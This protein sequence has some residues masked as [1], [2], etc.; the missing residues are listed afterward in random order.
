MGLAAR[1]F[2]AFP[3]AALDKPCS[4]QG[5]SFGGKAGH[6]SF[7][8]QSRNFRVRI[9][10]SIIVGDGSELRLPPLFLSL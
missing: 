5:Y 8:P 1:I 7:E 10:M 9:Y 3:A 6:E 4:L 2:F